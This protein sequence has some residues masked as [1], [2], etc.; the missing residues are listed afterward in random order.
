VI[1]MTHAQ[2][3]RITPAVRADVFPRVA[4]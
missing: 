1:Y 2:L 4:G 3:A